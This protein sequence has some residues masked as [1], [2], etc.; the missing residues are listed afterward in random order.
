VPEPVTHDQTALNDNQL[1]QALELGNVVL[2]YGTRKPPAGTRALADRIAGPFTPALAATG[3]AVILAR[4]AGTHGLVGLAWTHLIR[5]ASVSDPLLGQFTQ[6]W[7]G[8][9]AP[10]RSSGALGPAG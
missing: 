8:K 6:F 10:G 5:V 3:E 7:L 1:L 2:M 4:R 9:G